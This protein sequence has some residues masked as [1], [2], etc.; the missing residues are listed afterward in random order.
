M[1]HLEHN[2]A[3]ASDQNAKTTVSEPPGWLKGLSGE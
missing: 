2:L 1:D 3:H